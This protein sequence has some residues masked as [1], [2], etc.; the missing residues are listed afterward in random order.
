[1]P[2]LAKQFFI[3][4]FIGFG[5]L[6]VLTIGERNRTMSE[7]QKTRKSNSGEGWYLMN[8]VIDGE[9]GYLLEMGPFKTLAEAEAQF[10]KSAEY[11]DGKEVLIAKVQRR[12]KVK[13]ETVKMVKF[14]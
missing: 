9:D 8:A 13:V 7:E 11:F 5:L 10:K 3:V 6:A 4:G 12:I 2:K 14:E 1:M